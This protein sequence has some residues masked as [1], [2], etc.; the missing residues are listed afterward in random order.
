MTTLMQDLRYS[1]RMLTKSPGFTAVAIVALALGI[2]ANTAMYS[3][4]NAM[5]LRPF[6]FRDLDR[7]V[8]VWETVPK[9]N[10]HHMPVAPANFRDFQEQAKGLEV[11]SAVRGWSV[12]LT[13]K[14]LAERVEGY[15]VTANFFSLLGIPAELGRS[16]ADDNFG[17]GRDNVVVLSHGFWQ[18]HL[19]ADHA[20]VGKDVLLNGQKYTVIGIMPSDFD[21]PVGAEAWAPLDFTASEGSDRA[22]HY[23]EVF[24][25]L[26]SGV[27]KA[28]A[29]DDLESIA[30]RLGRDYPATNAGHSARVMGLVDDLSYGSKQFVGV[31]M[32]GAGLVLLLA[33]AN[34]AN[35]LLAR[36][37]GRQKEIAVR[38][39]LGA[40]R[41]HVA[42]QLIVESTLV[43]VMGGFAGL[44]LAAWH[45]DVT[46]TMLPPFIVQHVPGLKHLQVDWH[47]LGF[48]IAVAL[49]AGILAG[50]RPPSRFRDLT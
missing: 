16:I 6:P 8:S 9:Q 2:G 45:L 41:W 12:N 13:G 27:S 35:L 24:G 42:Q 18:R 38:L 40:S 15:Q 36:V 48:T 44:L 50:L 14:D 22:T 11:L 34:V 19:G 39:A 29:Q 10:Q 1:V 30:A 25:R 46:Q 4:I 26:K 33:C 47:V 7:A 23:L 43:S 5:L 37:T 20:I 21:F 28:K 31:L 3:I 32:G 17:T 49:L